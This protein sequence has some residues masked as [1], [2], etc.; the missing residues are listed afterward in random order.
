MANEDKSQRSLQQ[1]P[2]RES[3]PQQQRSGATDFQSRPDA[4]GSQVEGEGSYT[5]TRDYQKNIKDYLDKA[6]VKSDAEAS[7]PRSE[8]EAREMEEAERE[9][10]SHSKGEK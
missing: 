7:K 5:A 6:D 9:G 2:Q 10:K 4:Q 1:Q 8:S 3:D